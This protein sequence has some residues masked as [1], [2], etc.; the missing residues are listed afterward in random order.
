MTS[1]PGPI[2]V[3]DLPDVVKRYLEAHNRHDTPAVTATLTPEATITDEGQT[4]QG[5][6]AIE[7]WL[8]RVASEY[9]YTTTLVAA[10]LNSADHYTAVQHLEGDFPG[11]TVD[12]R[13]RFTLHH[14][15]IRHLTIAP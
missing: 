13:Y 10:E 6:P 1:T 15:L 4:Y 9:T 7:G 14:G 3:S 11:G 8:K 12:L 2:D 5:I